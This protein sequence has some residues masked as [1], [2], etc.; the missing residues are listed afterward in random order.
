M[1]MKY[2]LPKELVITALVTVFLLSMSLIVTGSERYAVRDATAVGE[3]PESIPPPV[4]NGNNALLFDGIDDCV[5]IPEIGAIR[6]GPSEPLTVEFWFF[7]PSRPSNWHKVLSKWGRGLGEDDE[8]VVSIRQNGTFGF[9]DSGQTGLDSKTTFPTNLWCHLCC[10]WDSANQHHA[11]YLNGERIPQ[12]LQGGDP[13]RLTGEPIRIGT[14]GHGD[15]FFAGM[16]DEVRIWNVAREQGQIVRD[17]HRRLRGDE[18]GLK[19]YWNFDEGQGQI[20]HDLSQNS[21]RGKLGRLPFRD[22]SD[23][24][25]VASGVELLDSPS[26]SKR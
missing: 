5:E 4:P 3:G 26:V 21:N 17:M 12:S 14:D 11:L 2:V 13:L 8:F 6:S 10:V 9:A 25:W 15:H 24:R 1:A 18:P 7:V 22:N 23:P 16:I 20:V 19:G